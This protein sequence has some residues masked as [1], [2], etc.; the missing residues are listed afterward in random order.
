MNNLQKIRTLEMQLASRNREFV[1]FQKITDLIQALNT[2]TKFDFSP[3]RILLITMQYIGG[4]NVCLYYYSNETLYYADTIIDQ[5]VINNIDDPLITK[6]FETS[7][8][9]NSLIKNN[10]TNLNLLEYEQKTDWIFPFTSC[11]K[12]IGVL[13]F[14]DVMFSQSEIEYF[15][16]LF[17]NYLTLHIF[18]NIIKTNTTK[19]TDFQKDINKWTKFFI[20]GIST[21]TW[22]WNI[23]TGECIFNNRWAE[24]IGYTL[25]EILPTTIKTWI[26]LLFPDDLKR[27]KK[28]IKNHLKGATEYLELESRLKHKNGNWIWVLNRG[29]IIEY[30]KEGKPLLIIGI[31]E[32][33]SEHKLIEEKLS[34]ERQFSQTFI[35]NM[36]GL[37]FLYSYP[38][39]QIVR[40]NRNHEILLGV[41][42]NQ[43]CNELNI[44]W[45]YPEIKQRLMNKLNEVAQVGSGNL[46]IELHLK[47]DST[48]PYLLSGTC[49]EMMG[50]TF[51]MGFGIDITERKKAEN[52]LLQNEHKF[53][54]IYNS[55]SDAIF[56][57]DPRT[58]TLIDS[59]LTASRMFGYSNEELSILKI[60][61]ISSP[62]MLSISN[63]ELF[64]FNETP[65]HDKVTFEWKCKRKNN[66]EFWTEIGLKRTTIDN[67]ERIVAVVRDMNERKKMLESIHESELQFQR[68]IESLPYA[69]SISTF[70]GTM[71][72]MNPKGIELFELNKAIINTKSLTQNLWINPEDR[73]D[74]IQKI[75]TNGVVKNYE[76]HLRAYSGKELWTLGSGIEIT[77]NNQSCILASQYDMT[78]RKKILDKLEESEELHRLMFNISQEAIAIV[79]DYRFIYFNPVMKELTGYS[80]Q[81]LLELNLLDIAYPDDRD[82]VTSNY[83]K[84]INGQEVEHRYQFRIIGK[85]KSVRWI[86][87]SGSQLI[88]KGK[89]SLFY[90]FNDI[91][92]QLT[93]IEKLSQSEE[94]YRLIAE[95]A[96]D[97]IW[98]ANIT[99]GKFTYVSPAIKMLRG[100]TVEEA[101]SQ[102]FS[103][104]L[105]PES[106]EI[107]NQAISRDLPLFLAAPE[108]PNSYIT[109]TQQFCKDGSIIWIEIATK[110]RFNAVGEI[111]VVGISRNIEERKKMEA[112]LR[113]LNATKDK[114]FS[115]IAHDLRGPFSLVVGLSE[116]MADEAF[117][118]S[119]EEFRQNSQTLYQTASSTYNL[120]ENLLEWSRLQR[121][122][123]TLKQ[124]TINLESFINNLNETTSE[125]AKKKSVKIITEILSPLELQADPNM[126]HSILRNLVTNAIKFTNPGGVVTIRI[127]QQDH[128]YTLF[129]ISDTGIGMSPDMIKNL[130]R[131]DVNTCRP[132]TNG[133]PSTGLGLLLCK[134]FIEK[135]GGKIWAESDPY[136]TKE[137]KGST[138]H[139]TIP[140]SG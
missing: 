46:E 64:N 94:K 118:L 45:N 137:N 40:W 104:V 68:I 23:Q 16:E 87:I 99:H 134:E 52:E 140:M 102:S 123:S 78:E 114:F 91:T 111:E 139:F 131:I 125:I 24:M 6:V 107:I 51:I 47:D 28:V 92:E 31:Q 128:N 80:D 36:P 15:T 83:Q 113:E 25:E 66:E 127:I 85:D 74:Y 19:Q 106:L 110:Y 77:Y 122:L 109:Q 138:F 43:E 34:L 101:L 79:Q 14:I 135:H 54:A 29:K 70:E 88:W 4:S 117:K 97:V 67:Q 56:I 103:D 59:N 42:S 1:Y 20:K 108:K 38:D 82:M 65:E 48:K 62:E 13:K 121:G 7:K 120:L 3:K 100:F 37:F 61:D 132:G 41:T 26:Q 129:S 112:E 90:F 63:E 44:E 55:T 27:N 71:L 50:K 58:N 75:K 8:R 124:E 119:I 84:R 21:A 69:I 130:F 2:I 30:T 11:E 17:L 115:I 12:T 9:S 39:L 5:T 73:K 32:D 18:N 96:S 98:I 76:M 126:L 57:L 86:S 133:E 116:I 81:E 33:I 93:A 72:Y 53:E 105:V 10:S 35:D 89:P 60:E 136:S 49:L 95:N 22:E